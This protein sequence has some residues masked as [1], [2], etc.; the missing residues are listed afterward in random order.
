MSL[1]PVFELGLWNV[2]IFLVPALLVMLFCFFVMMKKGA[3]DG[4][5]SVKGGSK[6]T[7][8]FASLSKVIYFPAVIY[9]VF[10]P[11]KFG[12]IW[13]Y[14]SLPQTKKASRSEKP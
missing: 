4:P 13:V 11:L 9:S 12:T 10:A 5:A 14:L 8:F 2:W 3:P 1:M 6:T 7:L